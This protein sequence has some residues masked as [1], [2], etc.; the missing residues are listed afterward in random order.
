MAQNYNQTVHEREY[1]YC[2]ASQSCPGKSLRIR[3]EAMLVLFK[4]VTYPDDKGDGATYRL[5]FPRDRLSAQ[6]QQGSINYP[7]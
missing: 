6:L 5:V 4:Y 2:S 1:E 7:T 3:G